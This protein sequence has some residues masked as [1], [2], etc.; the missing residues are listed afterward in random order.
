MHYN[1]KQHF[2][3]AAGR[4]GAHF[5]L[6]YILVDGLIYNIASYFIGSSW[7][8]YKILQKSMQSRYSLYN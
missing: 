6:M 5:S 4:D 1:V 3:I 2:N 8:V 7:F